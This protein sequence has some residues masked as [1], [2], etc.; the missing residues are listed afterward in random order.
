M[1]VGESVEA[2]TR[3][4]GVADPLGAGIGVAAVVGETVGSGDCDSVGAGNS[5]GAGASVGASTGA[6]TVPKI[7][8]KRSSA[9]ER[10]ATINRQ[11]TTRANIAFL[12]VDS[13]A[14]AMLARVMKKAHIIIFGRVLPEQIDSLAQ[15]PW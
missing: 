8:A 13:G 14:L 5:V 9:S 12:I 2:S 3:A 1:A 4:S 15:V 10:G 11:R 7:G 6:S